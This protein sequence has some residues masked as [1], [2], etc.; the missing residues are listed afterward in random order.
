MPLL[1]NS[2]HVRLANCPQGT[3]AVLSNEEARVCGET[4]LS[5]NVSLSLCL[6]DLEGVGVPDESRCVVVD[7]QD[8][9]LIHI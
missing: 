5:N 7:V 2:L 3:D 8:L 1:L 9:S 4:H 6:V